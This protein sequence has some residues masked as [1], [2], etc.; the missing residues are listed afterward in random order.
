M[1]RGD[2]R[3]TTRS[4]TLFYVRLSIVVFFFFCLMHTDCSPSIS[5][6]VIMGLGVY[7]RRSQIE[8][9]TGTRASTVILLSHD[10]FLCHPFYKFGDMTELGI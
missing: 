1:F 4:L 7:R 10:V 3:E 9:L 6:T 2:L 8:R 5:M